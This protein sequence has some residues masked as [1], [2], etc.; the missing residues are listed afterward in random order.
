MFMAIFETVAPV[1]FCA[2]IGYLWARGG[3]AYET[4]FVTRIV[5]YVGFP[6]LIFKT[7]I[8]VEVSA[9]TLLRMGGLALVTSAAFALIGAVGQEL[10]QLD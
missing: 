9:A 8:T 10:G 2:L 3:L 4:A 5:T 6:C 7:L 1:T